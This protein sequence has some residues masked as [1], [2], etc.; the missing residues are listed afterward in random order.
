MQ[1]T[2][3]EVLNET[4]ALIKKIRTEINAGK[5]NDCIFCN[6]VAELHD[7]LVQL[8]VLIKDDYPIECEH[9]QKRINR[10]VGCV[11]LNPYDFGAIQE[12]IS[13]LM[14]RENSAAKES[15]YSVQVSGK[16]IF[17]SHS[18]KDVKC[19]SMFVNQ[20]LSLGIGISLD[21]IFCTSIEDLGIKNGEDI[22]KHIQENIRCAE[23]SFL[24]I[25][26]NYKA[27]EIC[28]NEMGAVWAYD[29]KV[30]LYM[31]PG[32]T[33][34]KIGWLCDTRQAQNLS[35]PVVLDQ[36]YNEIR[37]HFSIT[38]DNF[39]H[40][41]RIREEFVKSIRWWTHENLLKKKKK[42]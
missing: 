42:F 32:A 27:S 41:S 7:L 13:L 30:R 4:S 19:V 6:K 29:A 20:I 26:D 37:S 15:P 35:D 21:D 39:G 28:I 14:I 9:L 22:R 31:L 11:K 18:S 25:S 33:V 17:I 2:K 8:I 1:K 40:W 38:T 23:Y 24:M 10:L 34:D 5:C 36:L 3:R 12:L 16:W